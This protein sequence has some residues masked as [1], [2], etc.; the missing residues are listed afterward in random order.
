MPDSEDHAGS[1]D[2]VATGELDFGRSRPGR[3]RFEVE[4]SAVGHLHGASQHIGVEL[5]VV[6]L[7][8]DQS[9]GAFGECQEHIGHRSGT[10]FSAIGSRIVLFDS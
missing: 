6:V 7:I 1:E 2:E 4:A 9:E 3:S 5:G 10:R 8:A